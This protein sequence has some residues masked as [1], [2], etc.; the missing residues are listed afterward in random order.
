MTLY[1]LECFVKVAELLSFVK[2]AEKMCISQ[3][4]ITYQIR[5]LEK[6]MDVILFERNTRNC[7]LTMAGQ[8]FY[9]DAIQLLTFS[10]H[11]VKKAQ[12]IHQTHKSHFR[13]GIRRLFDYDR[14]AIFVEEFHKEYPKAEVDI[15]SQNDT[16]PLDDLRTGK[17]DVG[18][19]YNNEHQEDKDIYFEPL[20]KMEYYVLM[21]KD[22]PLSKREAFTM[23]ELRN[24]PII[25]AGTSS[26]YLSA[27]QEPIIP[28]LINYGVD[29]SR[30]CSSFEGA[31]VRVR[32]G[33][34]MLVLPMLKSTELQG[35]VK[36]PV[37]GCRPLQVEI[38]WLMQDKRK[39]M[40]KVVDI[41]KKIYSSL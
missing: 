19:F 16:K 27:I 3:P 11:A 4:A 39:E 18:F 21:K 35:M 28:E 41:I 1:Q 15:L 36:V 29:L 10:N 6:E 12:D 17:I 25:T 9:Y 38:G 34:G 24:L 23:G 33:S 26:N 20:Y 2:A 8:T 30:T 13:I 7:S 32:S 22:N 5:S 37:L 14:L 40:P 31:M